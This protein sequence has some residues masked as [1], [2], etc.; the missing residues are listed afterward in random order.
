MLIDSQK[1]ITNWCNYSSIGRIRSYLFFAQWG[2]RH[3]C[4]GYIRGCTKSLLEQVALMSCF[5]LASH[6]RSQ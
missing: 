1:S 3:G 2:F 4:A 6:S 5:A